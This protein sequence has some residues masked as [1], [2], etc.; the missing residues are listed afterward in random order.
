MATVFKLLLTVSEQ[1]SKFR[2][3]SENFEFSYLASEG[4]FESS[5]ILERFF[6]VSGFEFYIQLYFEMVASVFAFL[7]YFRAKE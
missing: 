5:K 7:D 2:L 6:S 4:K 3:I 1:K